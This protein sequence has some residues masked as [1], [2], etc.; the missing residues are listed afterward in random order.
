MRVNNGDRTAFR[1][2]SLLKGMSG[3][4][5]WAKIIIAPMTPMIFVENFK[6]NASKIKLNPMAA[7]T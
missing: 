2:E 3:N 6:H 7:I 5:S 1:V 4:R